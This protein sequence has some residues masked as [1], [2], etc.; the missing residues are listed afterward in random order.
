MMQQLLST[1]TITQHEQRCMGRSMTP[2]V[3]MIRM[4]TGAGEM[5]KGVAGRKLH[6][7][8]S[9]SGYAHPLQT[10]QDTYV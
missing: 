1:T 4:M 5:A 6:P 9:M 7:A 3:M 8:P 10:S 2:C